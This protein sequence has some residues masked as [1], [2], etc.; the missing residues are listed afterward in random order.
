MWK[1]MGW[2]WCGVTWDSCP[3]GVRASIPCG[4]TGRRYKR[5]GNA[6]GGGNDDRSHYSEGDRLGGEPFCVPQSSWIQSGERLF[7]PPG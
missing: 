7:L 5:V 6:Q 4:G 2:G 1:G 3:G